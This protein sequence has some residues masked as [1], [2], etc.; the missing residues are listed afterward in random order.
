MKK[1][2]V[3]WS[4]PKGRLPAD[5]GMRA[6]KSGMNYQGKRMVF[7][8]KDSWGLPIPDEMRYVPHYRERCEECSMKMVCNG[9]SDCGECRPRKG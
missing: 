2:A 1:V 9:C 7:T 6:L 8:L 4:S 3:V 5:Y